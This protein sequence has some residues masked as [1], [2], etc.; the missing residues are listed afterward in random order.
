MRKPCPQFPLFAFTGHWLLFSCHCSRAT[1]H[2]SPTPRQTSGI[3]SCADPPPVATACHRTGP[4]LDE[5][6]VS[7]QYVTKPDDPFGQIKLFLPTRR[8]PTV[9]NSLVAG[10]AQSHRHQ[11]CL[12]DGQ[13]PRCL[14]IPYEGRFLTPAATA[15]TARGWSLR[16]PCRVVGC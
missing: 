15:T 6:P 9:D 16:G 14:S 5:R 11:A 1:D 2:D 3:R 7:I 10:G 12:P 13:K 8:R 4:D